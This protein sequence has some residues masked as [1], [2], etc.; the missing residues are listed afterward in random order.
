MTIIP[1]FIF[2]CNGS[3][4]LQFPIKSY[5]TIVSQT[6]HFDNVIAR[7]SIIEPHSK[8]LLSN[9]MLY[10]MIYFNQR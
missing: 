8:L 1:V 2:W 6:E 7:F 5:F 9:H 4:G 3:I 10:N